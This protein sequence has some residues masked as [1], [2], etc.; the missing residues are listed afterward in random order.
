M[1]NETAS[2]SIRHG[3]G[4]GV[5]TCWGESD[6]LIY[7]LRDAGVVRDP[8]VGRRAPSPAQESGR[9]VWLANQLADL[10]QIRSSPAGTTVR[11]HI[12]R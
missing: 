11:I 2:N 9:G 12:T 4:S 6:R 3:G 7:E 8:L 5:L 1:V 10:V